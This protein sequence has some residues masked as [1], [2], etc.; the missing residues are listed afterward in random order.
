M[1]KWILCPECGVNKFN[2]WAAKDKGKPQKYPY[3]KCYK[4]NQG[5]AEKS[6]TDSTEVMNALR[7]IY[8]KLEDIHNEVKDKNVFGA[9]E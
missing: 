6:G 7:K 1:S 9:D 4:C 5:D 8:G 2:P 3:K